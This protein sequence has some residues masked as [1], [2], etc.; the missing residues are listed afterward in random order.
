MGLVCYYRRFIKNFS[1]IAAP[2]YNLTRL[3]VKFQLDNNCQEAFD[4]FK[5][6]LVEEPILAYPDFTQKFILTTDS[7][8]T[9]LGFTL[10]QQI[11]GK[12]RP[13]LYG[14]RQF[15]AREQKTS[16]PEREALAIVV[17]VK[18]CH[19]YLHGKRFTI[20]TYHRPL[21]Y[22]LNS[23]EPTGKITRWALLLQSYDYD[24]EYRPGR[25]N[26]SADALS[27]RT[28]ETDFSDENDIFLCSIADQP[29]KVLERCSP[30]NKISDNEVLTGMLGDYEDKNSVNQKEAKSDRKI[31]NNFTNPK[32]S[33]KKHK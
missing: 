22:I 2:L 21:N 14:G 1:K 25:Q 13:I 8:A 23:E 9:G 33:R 11:N 30:E 16:L 4:I 5:Q 6:R 32:P 29:N 3:G 18:K 24:I 7:S 19:A 31:P 10:S 27:R 15:S 28:Y 20:V 12:E 26:C 17:A